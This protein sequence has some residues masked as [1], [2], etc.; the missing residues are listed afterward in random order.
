MPRSVNLS[1]E[2]ERHLRA[3]SAKTEHSE[4]YLLP[5][6]VERGSVDVEDYYLAP[7]VT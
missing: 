5:E 3:L 4:E 1:A 6:A 7:A 2:M